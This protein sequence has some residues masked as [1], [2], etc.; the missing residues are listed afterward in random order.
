MGPSADL[1]YRSRH[2]TDSSR[3]A[4]RRRARFHRKA[5]KRGH[6][7]R[8]HRARRRLG[9]PAPPR[10]DEDDRAAGACREL[11]ATRTGDPRSRRAS[12]AQQDHRAASRHQLPHRRDPPL[13]YRREA[14]GQDDL[15]T[16]SHGNRSGKRR[17]EGRR[18]TGLVVTHNPKALPS[19]AEQLSVK[20]RDLP[21]FNLGTVVKTSYFAATG[22]SSAYISGSTVSR[23]VI[24]R[25]KILSIA[26]AE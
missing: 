17:G 18:L 15:G 6:T 7:A 22:S 5:D 19:L 4:A 23:Q 24:S 26:R 14:R 25:G 12:R 9:R 21:A 13:P 16:R 20:L 1:H 2:D 8:Q 3:R 11:D 10:D